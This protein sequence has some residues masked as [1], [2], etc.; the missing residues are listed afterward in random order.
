[1]NKILVPTDF[2]DCA[3]FA[4]DVAI[5]LAPKLNAEVHFYTRVA[6]DANWS[7]YDTEIQKKYPESAQRIAE[8]Q[9]NL[10]ELKA[11]YLEAWP[12]IVATYSHGDIVEVISTYIDKE[13]ID[14]I[15]MGS[16]GA[17]GIK[18]AIFGSNAQKIVRHAH[19]P[20]MII[21]HPV[22]E[23]N[24]S[25]KAKAAF[26]K[27]LDFA[28]H[29]GAHI[30]L[31]SV[32]SYPAIEVDDKVKTRMEEFQ[33]MGHGILKISVHELADFNVELGVTHFAEETN[34]DL[35]ALANYGKDPIRR[36]FT[37]SISETLVNHLEIPLLTL[38]TKDLKIWRVEDKARAEKMR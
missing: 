27:L 28:Q 36:I 10:Q 13:N 12:S 4:A 20:V 7:D 31:V 9:K 1:V 16:S 19:C 35:I 22:A 37:G 11:S 6:V 24:L 34:A 15:V 26:Q 25:F 33:K 23:K 32:A 38:N 2:S 21:K 17:D 8:A 29:F 14:F 5:Q 18:E 30:H 3:G